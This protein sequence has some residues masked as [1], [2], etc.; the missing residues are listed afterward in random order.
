MRVLLVDDSALIRNILKEAFTNDTEISIV[1]EAMNGEKAIAEVQ[2]LSPDLV[3]M[4]INMPVMDGIR[5]T[6]RIMSE[7]PVPILVFSTEVDANL[8]YRACQAGAVDVLRKPDIGRLNDGAFIVRFREL[9]L[10]VGRER[11]RGLRT[12]SA[13]GGRPAQRVESARLIV[14]GAS[15]GG[16]SAVRTILSALK[17][18]VPV[19]IALVQ[20]LESGF[21]RG[22]VE[23]LNEATELNVTLVTRSTMMRGGTVYVAP[24]ERHLLVDGESLV[25][26]DGPPVLNQR[27]SVNRLFGSAAANY[28]AALL[29]V[30]LTGMGTDGAE[31]CRDIVRGGGTTVDEDRSTAAIFG[32]PRA[33]IE[34]GAASVVAPLSGI[35]GVILTI[36]GARA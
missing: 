13:G 15:T 11:S 35:P 10:S 5:A 28:R 27:P 33:A 31:G 17:R 26:D 1:G 6:E 4:D 23:W 20:H 32:M 30:L 18:N 36:L 16:P 19:P 24:S 9:L 7:H 3:I 14:M 2:R 29:G 8:G 22:Y 25:L 34:I 12:S 21:E